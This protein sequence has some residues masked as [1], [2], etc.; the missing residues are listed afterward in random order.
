MGG[1]LGRNS[2]ATSSS[3]EDIVFSRRKRA[4]R[5]RIDD[6]TFSPDEHSDDDAYHAETVKE[7]VVFFSGYS[8][9]N[10]LNLM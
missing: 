4:K 5:S 10:F 2:I 3:D 7:K 9:F 1:R 6:K 8:C